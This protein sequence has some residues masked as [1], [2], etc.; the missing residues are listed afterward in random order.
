[1][2]ILLIEAYQKTL[3]PDHGLLKRMFPGG[4]CKYTPTCS[5]Y[6]KGAVKKYGSIKGISKGVARIVRCNPCSKGGIDL[7]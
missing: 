7:P 1:M 4:Y 2:I 6:T 5:D 3:S